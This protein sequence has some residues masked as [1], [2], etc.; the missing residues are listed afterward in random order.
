MGRSGD[1]CGSRRRSRAA[2]TTICSNCLPRSTIATP[3][4]HRP[5]N[6]HGPGDWLL[7]YPLSW[8]LLPVVLQ[9]GAWNHTGRR[10]C[11]SRLRGVHGSVRQTITRFSMASFFWLD[12]SRV[13]ERE[14]K[15]AA[16]VLPRGQ[17][18]PLAPELD[19][20]VDANAGLYK[21][22]LQDC[23]LSMVLNHHGSR[24]RWSCTGELPAAPRRRLRPLLSL[25][26][27]MALSLLERRRAAPPAHISCTPTG[28]MPNGCA[29]CACRVGK[30]SGKTAGLNKAQAYKL[31]LWSRF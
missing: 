22:E 25:S 21:S 28:A 16:G 24:P 1:A 14:V 5:A 19:P 31:H 7:D 27:C 20:V 15:W 6:V 11:G 9:R 18:L 30:S 4:R 13:R 8:Q 26:R 29:Q 3:A 23:I 10:R 12:C 2:T 17:Q